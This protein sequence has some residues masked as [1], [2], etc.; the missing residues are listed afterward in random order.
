MRNR[1]ESLYGYFV[2]FVWFQGISSSIFLL[3]WLGFW[4]R[5]ISWERVHRYQNWNMF[6]A[7]KW[8]SVSKL[9]LMGREVM[10]Q[11]KWKC[12]IWYIKPNPKLTY[13]EERVLVVF[14]LRTLVTFLVRHLS[15]YYA[16]L[17]MILLLYIYIW[18]WW[19]PFSSKKSFTTALW[20]RPSVHP[21]ANRSTTRRGVTQDRLKGQ[22]MAFHRMQV[23][24]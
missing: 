12:E 16:F 7:R 17:W 9:R 6:I 15:Q 1:K 24:S 11:W 19:V 13:W 14:N 20:K 8:R 22:K 3:F 21:L 23:T 5:S 4:G 10:F 2:K 18:K